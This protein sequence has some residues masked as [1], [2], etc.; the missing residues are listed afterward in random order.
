MLFA[1]FLSLQKGSACAAR[2]QE[3]FIILKGRNGLPQPLHGFAMTGGADCHTPDGGL[4]CR[5]VGASAPQRCPPDTRTAMTKE[6]DLGAL[7]RAAENGSP[8]L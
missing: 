5:S 7:K 3:D 2:A 1:S 4:A 8:D 6:I